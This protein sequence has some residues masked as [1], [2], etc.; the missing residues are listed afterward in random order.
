M[1][2]TM[3][4]NSLYTSSNCLPELLLSQNLDTGFTGVLNAVHNGNAAIIAN[5]A[6]GVR[7]AMEASNRNGIANIKQTSD[8]GIAT[9]KEISDARTDNIRE[10]SHIGTALTNQISEN[11]A[12]IERTSGEGRLQMSITS[13][14]IRELINTSSTTNLLAIKDNLSVI[15]E[16]SCKTREKVLEDGCKTREESAEQFAALQL[17]ACQ[18][19]NDVEKEMLKGFAASQ[20]EALKN[21]SE[22]AA[23]IAECCCEQKQQAAETR[24]LILSQDAKRLEEKVARLEMVLAVN[25]ISV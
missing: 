8:I 5:D 18:N 14:E 2:N 7:D 9:I 23:Q 10:T 6:Q 15:R 21:K 13:G 17:Q 4:T 25:K 22:L 3:S 1:D 24:A 19:K 11:R 12:A 20:L 16:E